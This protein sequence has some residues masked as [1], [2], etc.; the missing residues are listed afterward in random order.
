MAT[1]TGSGGVSY[2]VH[3]VVSSVS[4]RDEEIPVVRIKATGS[5]DEAVIARAVQS[6][7]RSLAELR[8]NQTA[9]RK[10]VHDMTPWWRK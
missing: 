1:E 3:V 6:Y 10:P 4:G 2:G 9:T 7:A 8:A 5:R